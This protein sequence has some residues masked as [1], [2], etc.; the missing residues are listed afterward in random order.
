[1]TAY[2]IGQVQIDVEAR[3]IVKSGEPI[4]LEPRAFDAL[5]FLIGNRERVVSKDELIREVWRDRV[6]TDAAVSQAIAKVRRVFGG[7]T[8]SVISTTSRVGYRFVGEVA[9]P[10]EPRA[11]G[12]RRLRPAMPAVILLIVAAATSWWWRSS[13]Q[14]PRVAILPVEIEGDAARLDWVRFGVLPLMEQVLADDGVSTVSTGSVRATLK[15]H[16]K[17]SDRAE[18]ARILRVTSGAEQVWLPRLRLEGGQY[19]LTLDSLSDSTSV[20]V[21]GADPVLV[22]VRA[23]TRMSETKNWRAD[24]N[25]PYRKVATDDP[26]VNE[27]YARG[28]DARIRS[29]WDAA[30]DS[31]ETALNHAPDLHWARY[32]LSIAT[33]RLGQWERTERLN[34]ELLAAARETGDRELEGSVMSN[35]GTLAWRRGDLDAADQWYRSAEQTFD[36]IG[37]RHSIAGVYGNLAILASVRGQFAE[38]E[39][40]YDEAITRYRELADA[41][42][43]SRVLKNLGLMHMDR[44][45]LQTAREFIERSLEIRQRLG[46]ER[47]AALDLNALA[48]IDTRVG[49]WSQALGIQTKALEVAR[50]AGDRINEAQVLADI[51]QIHRHSG[52]LDQARETCG[53]ALF[54]ARQVGNPDAE[55]GVLLE[56]ARVELAAWRLD[57]ASEL[58]DQASE[59]FRRIDYA[60]GK[61]ATALLSLELAIAQ[62]QIADYDDLIIA[63]KQAREAVDNDLHRARWLR[64]QA[65]VRSRQGRLEVA[66]DS[67]RE[68]LVVIDGADNPLARLNLHSAF[69]DWAIDH[70]L[71]PAALAASLHLI[72]TSPLETAVSQRVLAR[73][74]AGTGKAKR[75]RRAALRW[76]ELAGEAFTAADQDLFQTIFDGQ[77]GT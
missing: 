44:G 7:E 47:E 55:A 22:A 74:F 57:L 24:P 19:Q 17:V 49:R 70:S 18:L 69:A 23:S 12:N 72:E 38:A 66:L 15:R 59:I 73:Y 58:N 32:Q 68:A 34:Q 41:E 1:M 52:A 33:R 9:E 4:A 35:A 10:E 2:R 67:W 62:D 5:I 8:Q 28:L 54:V 48:E 11:P 21:A 13:A 37:S 77:P 65:L 60:D 56:Q 30:R 64:L 42:N 71:N 50:A 75:S 39:D 51:C 76:R 40:F 26:F 3:E 20:V 45:Q 36:A 16:I 46:L 14:P 27:A 29:D 61:A 43:E 53:Q 25:R 6:V 31:F 63:A